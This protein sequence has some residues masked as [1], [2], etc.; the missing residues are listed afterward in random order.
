VIRI[1]ISTEALEDYRAGSEGARL[2]SDS[3][4]C[5][6]LAA[7]LA[8]FNPDHGAALGELRPLRPGN[9]THEGLTGEDGGGVWRVRDWRSNRPHLEHLHCTQESDIR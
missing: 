9:S 8:R 5:A 3:R 4:F 6:W 2:A 1:V 7:K